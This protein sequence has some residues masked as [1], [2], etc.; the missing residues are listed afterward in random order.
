MEEIAK[1]NIARFEW[2]I[3]KSFHVL[4]TDERFLS[5]T[6]QQMDL[7]YEHFKIDHP[8]LREDDKA[9]DSEYDE[10]QDGMQMEQ[11]EH[12]EDPDFDKAWNGEEED[13]E[14]WEEV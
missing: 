8:E 10:A 12:Y 7:L 5:L 14:E 6:E 2:W 1:T 11:H 9:R 3:Q 4:P 13:T